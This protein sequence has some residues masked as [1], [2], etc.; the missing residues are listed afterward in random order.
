MIETP[1]ISILIFEDQH[2]ID[3]RTDC[4]LQWNL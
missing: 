1:E 2:V 4:G 3:T